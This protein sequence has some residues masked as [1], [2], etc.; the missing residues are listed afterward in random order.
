MRMRYTVLYN[1]AMNEVIQ[2]Q[3]HG[4]GV[5]FMRSASI[6][7]HNL[8]MHWSGDNEG[9]FSYENGLPSVVRAGLSAGVSG[10]S[11]W[12]SDLGGYLKKQRTPEDTILFE[13]WT[14]Y[15]AFS[16][17]MEVMSQLNT[18]PWDWGDEALKIYRKFAVLHMSLFPYRYAAAQESARTGM[19]M[20]RALVLNHQEDE[21]ARKT[22]DEYEFGPDMLVAPMLAPGTQ[23][24]V[25][26]PEG[27][28][29]DLWTG[30]AVAG[31]QRV[32]ADVAIDSIAAYVR[33]GSIIPK[34][35]EDVMT[36]VPPFESGNHEIHSLDDR[37]VYEIFPGP[38]RDLVD[39]EDRR[40]SATRDRGAETLTIKGKAARVTVRF[41]FQH[42]TAATLNGKP[43]TVEQ[44]DGVANVSF[45]HH[46]MSNLQWSR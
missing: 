36:L 28:W 7:S 9:D 10:M 38:S 5:L 40:L 37:R 18:G 39:F 12:M 20:M 41:P 42:V 11:L 14:Q 34:I 30:K 44:H 46:D 17:G 19:P 8:S 45:V 21:M 24:A 1:N 4:N 26:L 43:I 2:K 3:L 35:P 13:R 29:L 23:R 31:R 33:A 25:Y 15:S 27:D 16:P 32:V 6:G 22:V